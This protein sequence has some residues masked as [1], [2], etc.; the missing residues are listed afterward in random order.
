[1]AMLKNPDV[2]AKAHNELDKVLGPGELPGFSD[3]PNLPYIAAIVREVG[4][5]NPVAPLGLC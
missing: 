3:E 4:R 2:Q 5:H 1:M